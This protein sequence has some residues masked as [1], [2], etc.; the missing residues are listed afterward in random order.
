MPASA[1][2]RHQD[3]TAAA[4]ETTPHGEW[5]QQGV[6]AIVVVIVA[7]VVATAGTAANAVADAVAVAAGA[8]DMPGSALEP[9]LDI[10]MALRRDVG[11]ATAELHL[12]ES[13]GGR[14]D[15]GS[16]GDRIHR[17]RA[18]TAYRVDPGYLPPGRGGRGRGFLDGI[19]D[20]PLVVGQQSS[21]GSGSSRDGR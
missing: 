3:A 13:V 20:R 21:S 17:Y 7:D 19:V 14:G 16:Y 2:N 12:A 15:G 8:G 6:V 10:A 11:E 1:A 5:G 18:S 4:V 9:G